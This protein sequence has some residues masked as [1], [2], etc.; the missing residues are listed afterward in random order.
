MSALDDKFA[1]TR[2]ATQSAMELY[3][4]A[5][6]CADLHKRA[7][8]PLPPPIQALVNA[9]IGIDASQAKVQAK[10]KLTRR[11]IACPFPILREGWISVA[12]V[13][14]L[15]Q[16]LVPTLLAEAATPYVSVN[17][18]LEQLRS[19]GIEVTTGGLF[20]AGTRLE[21]EGVIQ[22]GHLG[23]SLRNASRVATLRDERLHGAPTF[24]QGQE[25][26]TYRREIIL[27]LFGAYGPLSRAEIIS[28][29]KSTSWL[30]APVMLTAIKMDL[31]RLSESGLI[32]RS[33]SAEEEKTWT[34]EL[35]PQT[36]A[37][38]GPRQ[39]KLA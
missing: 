28:I 13:N 31:I 4:Q 12:V 15:P 23:W 37:Q 1:A 2:A 25:V 18:L 22:Y 14:V 38:K 36:K 26:A 6:Q 3:E 24:F 7:G 10:P 30:N 21:R 20:N 8:Q 33:P 11:P 39:L 9:I 5:Q 32:R 27:E 35:V 19:F 34:W 29:L 16:T 17:V